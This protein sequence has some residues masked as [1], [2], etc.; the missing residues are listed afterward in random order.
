MTL[1][2]I[3]DKNQLY[4][5]LSDLNNADYPCSEEEIKVTKEFYQINK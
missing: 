5:N 2:E 1:C 3:L 4:V